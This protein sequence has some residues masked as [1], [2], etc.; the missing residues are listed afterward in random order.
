M[1]GGSVG[2]GLSGGQKRRL[3]IALQ[4]LT[5]PSVIFLDEPTSGYIERMH[6]FIRVH[7][8]YICVLMLVMMY[9]L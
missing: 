7:E 4:L 6:M 3:V 5:M 1:V 2:P 8:S 9:V